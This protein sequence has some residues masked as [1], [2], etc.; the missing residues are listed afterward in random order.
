M[1]NVD[2]SMRFKLK[3]GTFFMP[4]PSSVY[5]RNNSGSFRM[6][7][8]TIHQWIEKLIPMFNGEYSLANLTD[9]LSEPYRNRVYEITDTLFTNGFLRDVSGDRPHKLKQH[10]V[11]KFASQI[12]YIESFCDSG[13]YRF[14]Q[15]RQKNVLA[16][17]DDSLL[18]GLVSSLLTSGMARFHTLLTETNTCHQRI[19]ELETAA[20]K[21]DPDV[22][23]EIVFK[24]E[25]DPI[26][27][28]ELIEPFDAILYVS[29]QGNVAKLRRI[30]HACKEKKKLFIPAIC[31]EEVGM[32]GPYVSPDSEGDW[33]SAWQIFNLN[34]Q[35]ANQ[36]SSFSSPAGA[37]L[38]NV[39]V[40]ELF[41][42]I[43]GVPALSNNQM[44]LLNLKTLE[45]KWHPF[46]PHP[47]STGK[48]NAIEVENGLDEMSL[49][50]EKKDQNEL[51]YYFS[52]LTS[53]QVGIFRRWEEGALSQLPLSQC[54]VQTVNVKP[55]GSS[56]LDTNTSIVCAAMTH[57][58][59]R[60]EAGLTGIEQYVQPLKDT[61]IS[62]LPSQLDRS[63][64]MQSDLH[65]GAGETFVE[66]ISRALQKMLD[67][68]WRK[69]A[70]QC[71]AHISK[72]ACH[73]VEDTHCRYYLQ[74]LTTMK[75]G[76]ELGLGKDHHGLPVVWR[77]AEDNRWYGS[78][79]FNLTLALRGALLDAVVEA[80]NKT[81]SSVEK[82][83]SF[84][85]IQLEEEANP[86]IVVPT[87]NPSDQ[88]D[89]LRSVMNLFD[90]QNK[91]LSFVKVI[92][93]PFEKDGYISIFGALTGEEATM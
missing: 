85:S 42:K 64:D 59:A 47:L 7:G 80:Q 53:S 39:I 60:R 35:V 75:K 54:E 16:I 49:N 29:Q 11:E 14:Q 10:V 9:G 26:S 74:A 30:L 73:K 52:K 56:S 43:T 25:K 61:I 31:T 63:N 70:V 32:G 62:S 18:T 76:P 24:K 27:W 33:E 89:V 4:E 22:S 15:Y 51:L 20:R 82:P 65:I 57:K 21:T 81:I 79:G 5:F 23:I 12:E 40:F 46:K 84:P 19:L 45:G 92:L 38:A 67:D 44:F 66:G 28:G 8:S 58:E 68:E 37:M 77:K 41:K 72:L 50:N 83:P 78:V 34:A 90:Q 17:G 3:K 55:I 86:P 87:Y 36:T 2:P 48:I 6:E 93:E 1:T 69:K 91:K 88:V 71:T 13:A